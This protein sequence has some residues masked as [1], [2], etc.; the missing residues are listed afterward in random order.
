[1][2][3]KNKYWYSTAPIAHGSLKKKKKKKMTEASTSVCLILATGLAL[4]CQFVYGTKK[5][6]YTVCFVVCQSVHGLLKVNFCN[7]LY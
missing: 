6:Y 5:R 3:K 4:N 7:W 2:E 1:M